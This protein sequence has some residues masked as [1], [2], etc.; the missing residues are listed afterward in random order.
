MYKQKLSRNY[1]LVCSTCAP[2]VEDVIQARTNRSLLIALQTMLGRSKANARRPLVHFR[3]PSKLVRFLWILKGLTW[4]AVQLA[5]IALAG[6]CR[7]LPVPTCSSADFDCRRA[8][9]RAP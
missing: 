2:A 4:M 8:V 9:A 1:P 6:I 5:G 3:P 7:R